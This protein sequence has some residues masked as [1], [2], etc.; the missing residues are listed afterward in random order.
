MRTV[1]LSSILLLGL[2]ASG[3]ATAADKPPKWE[4]AEL[5]YRV[6]P[7]QPR[8]I[9]FDG[10]ETPAVPASVSIRWVSGAGEVEVKSWEE[11]AEKV[12]APALKDGSPAYK[13]IQV[14]NYLGGEG[15]ELMDQ[16]GGS[17]APAGRDR[18]PG[19]GERVPIGG[20]GGGSPASTWLFKR[21]VP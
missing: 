16:Q 8:G 10:K 18:A 12:K 14:L 9:D 19:I 6:I 4:Y 15:W 1:L 7:G 21:R 3:P 5:T 11:L 13:K 2:T 20:S 17:P